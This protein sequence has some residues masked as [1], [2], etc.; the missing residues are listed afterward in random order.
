MVVGSPAICNGY[1]SHLDHLAKFEGKIAKF[2][3]K[4]AKFEG[5][6]A[7]FEGKHKKLKPPTWHQPVLCCDHHQIMTGQPTY[8]APL[9]FKVFFQRLTKGNQVL[10]SP[11]DPLILLMEEILLHLECIKPRK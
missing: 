4:L 6:I 7:K 5:K 2:E 1:Q 11:E 9:E 10:I 8:G 3:G